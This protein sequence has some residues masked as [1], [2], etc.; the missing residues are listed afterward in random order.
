VSRAKLLALDQRLEQPP[1]HD[2]EAFLGARRPPRCLHATDGIMYSAECFPPT[3]TANLL[4]ACLRM[5]RAAGVGGRQADNEQ[6]AFGEFCRLGQ[7]LRESEMRLEAARRQVGTIVELSRI[8]HPF[9][10]QDQ[11]RAVVFHQRAQ[12]VARAGGLLVVRSHVIAMVR[13]FLSVM[14]SHRWQQAAWLYRRDVVSDR[15]GALAQRPARL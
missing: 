5:G 14:W 15:G 13:L 4:V 10:D 9:V 12:H 2:L 6:T 7:R 1:P 8:R 3:L 11:T